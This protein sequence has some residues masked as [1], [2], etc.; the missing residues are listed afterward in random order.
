MMTK[1][2]FFCTVT[3]LLYSCDPGFAVVLNNNS[4]TT[5]HVT[6]T[7]VSVEEIRCTDS[8]WINGIELDTSKRFEKKIPIIHKD[9]VSKSYGFSLESSKSA[10]VYS[11][12]GGYD[13]N[14]KIVIDDK[15]TISMK[16]D[17][18][19]TIKRKWMSTLVTV[20]AE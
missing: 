11:G 6:I 5:K 14:K 20:N 2:L 16:T 15:D 3:S 7:N 13:F 10:L 19:V 17:K 8:L 12:I 1:L 4:N 18:R 9:T